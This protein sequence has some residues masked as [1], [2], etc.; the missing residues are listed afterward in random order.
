MLCVHVI[1]NITQAAVCIEL[2]SVLV[3]SEMH[4]LRVGILSDI[5]NADTYPSTK[6]SLLSSIEGASKSS[7]LCSIIVFSVRRK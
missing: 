5:K 2:V 3:C 1:F 4:L 6:T 7:L